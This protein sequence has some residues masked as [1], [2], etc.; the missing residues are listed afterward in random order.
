MMNA[1]NILRLL[2][3]IKINMFDSHI[4]GEEWGI[5]PIIK[6]GPY[7]FDAYGF[8]VFM[9]LILGLFLIYFLLHRYSTRKSYNSIIILFSALFFGT[10]G[11]KLPIWIAHYKL[12]FG[13]G[14]SLEKLLIGRTVVGGFIGGFI[15]VFL[16]KKFLGIK[17]RCGNQLASGIALAMIFG[18]LGCFFRGCCYGTASNLHWAVDFGDGVLRHPTQLYEVLFHLF[19][20][21]FLIW[22]KSYK[23]EGGK[24]L[25]FYLIIYFVYRFFSE[26]IRI[27][28]KVAFGLTSYQLFCILGIILIMIKEVIFRKKKL[29]LYSHS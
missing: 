23:V 19:M 4:F 18:R 7:E 24:Y 3:E 10:L 26:F 15:G 20:L 27:H 6:I 17:I 21:I 28:E 5:M 14:F 13:N 25:S 29:F 12:I 22:K 9:G 16:T 2:K 11:A 8:F 1:V